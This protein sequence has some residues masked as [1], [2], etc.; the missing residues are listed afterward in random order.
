VLFRSDNPYCI[1]VVNGKVIIQVSKGF[2]QGLV[3]LK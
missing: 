3:T 2:N 1:P